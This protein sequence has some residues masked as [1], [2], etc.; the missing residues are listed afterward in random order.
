MSRT[1]SSRTS[2]STAE[3][4][5]PRTSTRPSQRSSSGASK[6][7]DLIDTSATYAV[8]Y[9]KNN[10]DANLDMRPPTEKLAEFESRLRDFGLESEDK[11]EILIHEKSLNHIIHGEN[12]VEVLRSCLALGEFYNENQRPGSALRH[13]QKASQIKQAHRV[14]ASEE[15]RIAVETAAAYLALRGPDRAEN[16]KHLDKASEALKGVL[17]CEIDDAELR[18]RRDLVKA[19]MLLARNKIEA[20]MRQYDVAMESLDEVNAGEDSVASA[21]LYQEVAGAAETAKD[22]EKAGDYFLK[23]Y[24][25]FTRLGLKE[26]AAMIK[27]KVPKDKLESLC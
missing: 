4:R 13:L 18:Y 6:S 17:D 26:N 23:A 19:R 5:S 1:G 24:T 20:A 16:Q 21:K 3:G 25:A 11:F 7:R 9:F 27:Q 12:S 2:R 10:P 14:G 8:A 15:I 22:S